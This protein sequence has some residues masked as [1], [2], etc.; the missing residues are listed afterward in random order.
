M[1]MMV[2]VVENI[3]IYEEMMQ[4]ARRIGQAAELEVAQADEN[5]TISPKIS[6]LMRDEEVHRLI[7]PKEFGHPQLDWRTFVDFVSEVGYYNLSASW[8]AYFFSA[9]NAWVNYYPKHIRDEVIN[10]GG[11]VAD[12]FAPIGQVEPTEGGYI[13]SGKYNF[14]SGINYCDWVGVGAMMKFEDN[15]KPERVGIL[16]KVSDLEIIKTWDSLGLRGSGSNTL[17][18][19]KVFVKPDAI[20]RFSKIIAN[21]QPPYEDFDQDYLYY[22]T[23][24]YPGFYVGFPAMAIGGARRVLDEFEKHTAGRVR[25]SGVNEK[26]SPTSQRVLAKLKMEML[27]AES[28]MTEYIRMMEN[29][30][31]GPY[32]GAKYKVIRATI[33]EKCTEI[34]VRALLTLG[35]H[36]LLKGHP[37]ELFSRDLIAIATHITSL[38]EDGLIGYGRHLFGVQTNIQG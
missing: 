11:F 25:F 4:K 35:G 31:G 5:S 36:A 32:E 17:V 18:V 1:M 23:P 24:F 14:V 13:V 10:Q 19:D 22:N 8:L 3:S 15:D 12:V 29:D 34:G 30:K 20:L 21:S 16:L 27:T 2:T 9:H 26:D 6:Q 7:L 28:L 37:V 33:I 38:Y